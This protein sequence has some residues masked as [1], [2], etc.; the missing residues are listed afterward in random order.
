M[1]HSKL[2]GVF[3]FSH[4]Y[5]G[6]ISDREIVKKSDFRSL[7]EQGDRYLADKGFDIHDLMALKGASLYI[8]PKQQSVQDQFN[9]DECL[10]TMSI[11]NVRIH[12]ERT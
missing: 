4:L 3:F 1:H 2:L 12:V 9:K 5:P 6:R 8:P 11:A 10:Q 7:I